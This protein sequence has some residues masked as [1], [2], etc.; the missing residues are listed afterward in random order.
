MQVIFN[1]PATSQTTYVVRAL[2]P[3][4]EQNDKKVKLL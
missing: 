3:I 2:L 1:I 4:N